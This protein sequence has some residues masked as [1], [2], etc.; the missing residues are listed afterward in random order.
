[1]DTWRLIDCDAPRKEN[2]HKNGAI[3][4]FCSLSLPCGSTW[5]GKSNSNCK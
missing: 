4:I 5:E 2:T 1:L 3:N